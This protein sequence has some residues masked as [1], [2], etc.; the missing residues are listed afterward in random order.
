MANQLIGDSGFQIENV[1]NA[2]WQTGAD[3]PAWINPP[4]GTVTIGATTAITS[5]SFT[6][7]FTYDDTDQSDFEYQ[8]DAGAIVGLD[9]SAT[10]FTVTGLTGNTLYGVKVRAVNDGGYGGWATTDVTTASEVVVGWVDKQRVTT[11][12]TNTHPA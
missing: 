10:S 12:W 7:N 6:I 8:I 1:D 9:L 2:Q 5:T 4:Q 3:V 11:V